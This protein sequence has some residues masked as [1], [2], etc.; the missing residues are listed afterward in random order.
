MGQLI[1]DENMEDHIMQHPRIFLGILIFSS[2]MYVIGV[3]I[4]ITSIWCKLAV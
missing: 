2:V 4:T 3:G 1:D